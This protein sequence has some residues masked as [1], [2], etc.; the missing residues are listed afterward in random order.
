MS[1][2]YGNELYHHGIKGQRWGERNYQ[3]PDGSLTAAG[4]ER[5]RNAFSGKA[6]GYRAF[7]K[8]SSA[9]SKL[10]GGLDKI[11]GGKVKVF[12]NSAKTQKG[13]A[14][15]FN[16]M[17]DK[18]QQEANTKRDLKDYG[19]QKAASNAKKAAAIGGTA[20]AAALAGYGIYRAVKGKGGT[21]ALK[22]FPMKNMP[23]AVVSNGK[24]AVGGLLRS[25]NS[26]ANMGLNEVVV[27]HR[28]K[29]LAALAGAGV[30]ADLAYAKHKARLNKQI[31]IER[32]RE[33]EEE[34]E[35]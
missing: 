17:A 23:P 10:H 13:L 5:Y 22:S 7:S 16:R 32:Q 12:G 25:S 14:S 15:T 3:N 2:Y 35:N 6:L 4:R 28:P 18:A 1:V 27:D 31:A 24:N 11:T 8:F 34:E 9:T 29:Q 21:P 30:L 33:E 26:F 19:G 20:V